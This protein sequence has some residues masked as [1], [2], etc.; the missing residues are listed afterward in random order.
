[1]V[2][3]GREVPETVVGAFEQPSEECCFEE[4]E[5]EDGGCGAYYFS[6]LGGGDDVFG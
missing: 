6:G 3:R 2:G 1:M 5:P 4:V